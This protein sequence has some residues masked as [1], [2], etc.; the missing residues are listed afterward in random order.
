M[1]LDVDFSNQKLLKTPIKMIYI[2]FIQ[3]RK[4][5]MAA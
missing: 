3:E 2:L 1:V 4:L 5:L